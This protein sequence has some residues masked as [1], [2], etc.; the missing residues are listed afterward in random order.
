MKSKNMEREIGRIIIDGK[1]SEKQVFEKQVS[2]FPDKKKQ[3]SEY[4]RVT[5]YLQEGQQIGKD[6][7]PGQTDRRATWVPQPQYPDLP[8]AILLASDIHYGSTRIDYDLLEKHLKIVEDTPNFYMCTNGDH[9]DNFN[10]VTHATGMTENPLPPVIQGRVFMERLL[11]LDSQ[12]KIGVLGQGNH[13]EFGFVAGQD[14]YDTFMRDFSA[15]I[16]TKGGILT[17][18]LQGVDYKMVLNHTYWGKSKINITNASKRLLEYEG[19]GECDIGWLGHVHQSSYELFTKGEKEQLAVV[20][21]TYKTDDPWAA[22]KGIGGR[23]G[24]PGITVMLW[25]HKKKMEVFKDAE[26]A[27]EFMLGMIKKDGKKMQR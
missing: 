7:D 1:G 27:Q 2:P 14:F 19:G 16:F 6:F 10:A 12:K 8:I 9:I 13:D 22:K 26:I 3:K 25:P 24:H 17:I 23:G 11:E 5:K 15:P 21:G 20:S 4:E 18:K